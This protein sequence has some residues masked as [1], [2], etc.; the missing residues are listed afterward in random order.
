MATAKGS[1][2]T[3]PADSR[4]PTPRTLAIRCGA[5]ARASFF[6]SRQAW[7]STVRVLPSDGRVDARMTLRGQRRARQALPVTFARKQLDANT[8]GARLWRLAPGQASTRH[9]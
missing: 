2:I 3:G 7:A 1:A 4:Y 6:R 9:R 8:L 5:P